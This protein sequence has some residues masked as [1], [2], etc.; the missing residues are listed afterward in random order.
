MNRVAPWLLCLL[1]ATG[2]LLQWQR[3]EEALELSMATHNATAEITKMHLESTADYAN[4]LSK[5]LF[6]LRSGNTREGYR[7]LDRLLLV[8]DRGA[9]PDGLRAQGIH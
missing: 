7:V 2:L 8:L 3:A 9:A 5:G 4:L 1:L 6:E